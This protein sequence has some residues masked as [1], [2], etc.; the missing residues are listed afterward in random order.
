ML[1]A[2]LAAA[3]LA[4]SACGEDKDKEGLSRACPAAPA[5]LQPAPTLPG[6]FP[7]VEGVTYTKVT[8]DGP[9]TIAVGYMGSDIG[10][11]HDA[12]VAAVSGADGYDV[13]KEEQDAADAEV[14]FSGAGQSGQVKLLQTCKTRTTVTI[15]IRPA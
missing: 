6:H 1:I 5:A 4:L 13:T 9:S 2:G 15:T 8:K 10:D 14:N 12:Y 3:V 11:A 7:N